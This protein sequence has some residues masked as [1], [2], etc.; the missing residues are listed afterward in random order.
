MTTIP[1]EVIADMDDTAAWAHDNIK[2]LG[3]I[4]IKTAADIASTPRALALAAEWRVAQRI[5]DNVGRHHSGESFHYLPVYL[6][7]IREFVVIGFEYT[8]KQDTEDGVLCE[9][10]E[11]QA[12][13]LR[14]VEIGQLCM[15][16][17]DAFEAA[18]W[19]SRGK[20]EGAQS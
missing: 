17:V 18:I 13:W 5:E 14:G 11:I 19:K 4:S 20:A 12:V 8:P 15:P 2:R 6:S 10:I 16:N 3:P 9:S 1:A 7:V